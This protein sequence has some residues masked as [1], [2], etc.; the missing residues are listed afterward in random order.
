MRLPGALLLAAACLWGQDLKIYTEF[1]RIDPFGNVAAPDA[2]GTPREILSPVVARNAW[3]SFHI[4]CTVAENA[5]SFLYIQQN[6]ELFEVTL[7]KEVFA[8]TPR[9]WIPDGLEKAA[10]PNTIILP[11]AVR[12]IPKQ[13]TVVFW[14]DI[15]IPA[16]TPPG[17][18]RF[19]A[20]LKSG[21]RWLVYPMEVRVA[22]ASVA[23]TRGAAGPLP[24]LTGRA[25][26]A[27]LS[28]VRKR[29]CGVA[30]GGGAGGDL[31]VRRMIRRNALQDLSLAVNG[32]DA[33]VKV[34]VCKDPPPDAE[35]WVPVRR[36]IYQKR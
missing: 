12:P 25:D 5:P 8:N 4:A 33:F 13:N 32:L 27:L 36:A 11:D 1:R 10:L 6:P 30:E 29:L 9:G 31:T 15:R 3:A 18:M 22:E 20:V 2:G 34:P 7:Y 23:G 19:Q 17:R 16:G 21:D 24:A 28:V 14:L 26:A 35:W